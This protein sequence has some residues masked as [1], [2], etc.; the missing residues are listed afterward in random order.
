MQEPHP[1]AARRA[2]RGQHRADLRR[3][4]AEAVRFHAAKATTA[5][6]HAAYAYRF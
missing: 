1:S 3:T 2:R 5:A 6:S 4:A